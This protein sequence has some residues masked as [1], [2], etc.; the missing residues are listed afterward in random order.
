GFDGSRFTGFD[1]SDFGG[2]V[3][4]VDLGGAT[5]VPA[6]ADCHVHFTGTGYAVGARDLRDV[7]DAREFA[8]RVAE[9]EPD[10]SF[11][12]AGSY[13][14]STWQDGGQAGA[15][16]LDRFHPERTTLLVR[17][18]GHS[19]LVNR[20]TLA[21][22]ALEDEP[23]GIER[24]S[25]GTP[26]GR[27]FGATNWLAQRRFH[28]RVPETVR[29]AAERRAYALAL[30][31][32]AVHLHAQLM[33][34]ES[35]AAYAHEIEALREL[36]PLKWYPKICERD[37]ALALEL[38]LPFIGGDVF[39]DGSFGSGSAAL[40]AP[41]C[42]RPGNG[43]LV[44]DDDALHEFFARAEALGVSAGVHAIGDR[45]IEQCLRAWES[46]LAGRPSAR[47][48][49]FIEHFELATPEQI[50]RSARLGLFLSMQPQFEANWGG[51]GGMYEARLGAERAGRLNALGSALRAGAT[52]CG[53]DDS[54][55]CALSPLRGMGAACAHHVPAERLEPLEALTMY[56]YDAARLGHAE[57]HAGALLPGYDADFVVLDRDPFDGAA[58]EQ[59]RVLETWI[60]GRRVFSADA[61]VK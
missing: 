60:D 59:T 11:V 40:R 25:D 14:E 33:G 30:G 34:F 7:R 52:L 51:P 35:R 61:V 37:P 8:R 32:G 41:Y 4:R 2:G 38:G 19:A 46:V 55:V 43:R 26:T 50:Q 39:L 48:R 23:D 53:G 12:L 45:A 58:F 54:P 1:A 9:L 49:H 56:T 42:D 47:N 27:L 31:A 57:T 36:G 28:A 20:K 6:F 22:L 29:R 10:G 18:D 16:V 17:V 5:V 13:D 15:E 24:A 3:E 44:L 21:E